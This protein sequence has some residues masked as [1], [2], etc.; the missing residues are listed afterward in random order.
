MHAGRHPHACL[1]LAVTLPPRPVRQVITVNQ[2][3]D[4]L[5][6]AQGTHPDWRAV[7]EAV[8]PCRKRADGEGGEGE[9][10]HGQAGGDADA[11]ADA[12]ADETGAAAAGAGAAA[13]DAAPGGT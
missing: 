4:I 5:A 6:R 1:S 9:Q 3:V 2:V 13:A 10:E 11:D 8:L 7:L 12:D